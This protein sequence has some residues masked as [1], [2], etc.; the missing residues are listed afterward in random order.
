MSGED[1]RPRMAAPRM[2]AHPP[3]RRR[4]VPLPPRLTEVE[5]AAHRAFIEEMG[6]DTLWH[7]IW[8]EDTDDAAAARE[9]S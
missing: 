8:A 1:E 9:D 5:R 2:Q 6:T 7:R 4:P 3:Q